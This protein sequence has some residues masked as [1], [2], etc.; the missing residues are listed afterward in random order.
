MVIGNW[1]P[2]QPSAFD[3][4]PLHDAVGCVVNKGLRC[5]PAAVHTARRD[6]A[7][8]LDIAIDGFGPQIATESRLGIEAEDRHVILTPILDQ[9]RTVI[10]QQFGEQRD[11]EAGKK[12]NQRGEGASIAFEIRP[13]AP[14]QVRAGHDSLDSKSMRGSIQTYIRS[15]ISPMR[16]PIRLKI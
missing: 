11:G 3:G 6:Q 13:A 5:V 1:R 14:V 7:L 2:D 12:H 15:D 8:H 10:C 16:S 4:R 9:D